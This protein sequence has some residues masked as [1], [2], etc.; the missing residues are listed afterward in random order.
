MVSVAYCI[1]GVLEAHQAAEFFAGAANV[2]NCL[3]LCG[4]PTATFDL[5]RGHKSMDVSTDAGFAFD[6]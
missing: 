2:S 4:Y 3:R 5:N 1:A 6:T